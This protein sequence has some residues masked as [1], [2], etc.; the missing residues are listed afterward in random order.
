MALQISNI[1]FIYLDFIFVLYLPVLKVSYVYSLNGWKVWILKDPRF[2]ATNFLS[3]FIF[4][5]YLLVYPEIVMCLAY[6]SKKCDFWQ[7]WSRGHKARGQ[8][9]GHKKIRG[10]GQGQP[11]RGQDLSR[12]RTGMLEAKVKDQGQGRKCSPK[13]KVFKKFFQAISNSLAYPEFLIG[14]GLNHKSREMT[15]SKFFQRG[16]FRRMEDLKSLPVGT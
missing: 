2:G 11:F 10:Q 4:L 12:Q 15:S 16:S 8:G 9:Q 7:R 3:N 1:L 14:G 13:K 6:T 5:S